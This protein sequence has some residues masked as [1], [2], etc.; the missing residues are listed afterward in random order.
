MSRF[1]RDEELYQIYRRA[2]EDL[3][4]TVE[5]R[6]SLQGF[7]RLARDAIA[8]NNADGCVPE[9]IEHALAHPAMAQLDLL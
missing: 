2:I 8:A 7:V 4:E 1:G 5:A 9:L 3:P 6:T